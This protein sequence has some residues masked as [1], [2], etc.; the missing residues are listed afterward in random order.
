MDVVDAS[1]R[2]AD[3]ESVT[4]AVESFLIGLSPSD[5]DT[6]LESKMRRLLNKY[7]ER[8]SKEVARKKEWQTVNAE[9]PNP[10]MDHPTDKKQIEEAQQT[11]GNYKLKTDPM[12][13]ASEEERETIAQKLQ[14]LL[15]TREDVYNIRKDYNQK[16]TALRE[17]KRKLYN[18]IKRKLEKL[19]EIHMEIPEKE[20]MKPEV[21]VNFEFDD[22]FPERN[23]DLRKYLMPEN[24]N[25]SLISAGGS[26]L[27]QK[28]PTEKLLMDAQRKVLHNKPV[29]ANAMP[30]S[31]DINM[32]QFQQVTKADKKP[33]EWEEELKNL[34]TRR[35]LFEQQQIIEK[36][37]TRIKTFDEE[38][39]KVSDER[40]GVEVESKFKE[41][42][43]LTLNHELMILK[44]FESIEDSLEELV[45]SQDSERKQLES[46]IV[47][48]N[49]DIE[50]AQRAIEE[51]WE[52]KLMID[53]KFNA[54]CSDNKF[55]P[56]LKRV[57][58]KKLQ[59]E[60]QE[61][62]G[63][64]EMEKEISESEGSSSNNDSLEGSVSN[65]EVGMKYLSEDQCPKGCDTKLY[66]LTF[67]LRQE[68]HKLEAAI[69]EKTKEI[70]NFQIDIEIMTERLEQTNDD[71]DASKA[72]LTELRQKKQKMLNEVHT[73]VCL[74]MDQMQYF[75]NQ[76][77]FVDIDNT[78]L[79]NNHNVTKLYSRVGKL[80]LETIEAKRKHRINVIH[81]AKMKTD[82]KF[83]EK[84]ITDLKDGTNQ[85][86]LKKFGRVIDLNEVEE[87]ILRRFAFEMQVEM[88]AN[89]EDIK[90]QYFNKINELKK[91]KI[92]KEENLKRIIQEA[93]E[94]LNI[95]T[96]LEEEKNFLRRIMTLQSRKQE[97]K[98]AGLPYREIE[99]DLSKL[100]E[101]SNHQKE[102]IEMLQREIRALTLKSK[103][104]VNAR[105]DFESL[106]YSILQLRGEGHFEDSICSN[107][108]ESM[109]SSTRA[110]TPD[111]EVYNEI[112]SIV[113]RFTEDHL[114]DQLEDVEIENVTLNLAKYLANVSVN[115]PSSDI[116]EILPE[117][118]INFKNFL[119]KHIRLA[120]ENI[121]ELVKVIG[122]CN[123]ANDVNRCDVL[124]E[125]INNTIEAANQTTI[126]SS[127][128]LQVILTEIFKQM[129]IT[130]R[131]GDIASSDCTAEIIQRLSKLNSIQP[132]NVNLE[133]IVEE[134][135][136]HAN[137]NMED[138]ID[139]SILKRILANI[140]AKLRV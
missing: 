8:K 24:Y 92:V 34:R 7:R 46:R 73:V 5:I 52:T 90:R 100:Q 51:L 49:N 89:A 133:E 12:F 82:C 54:S 25:L 9:K 60:D 113:K 79:F 40:Y 98:Q 94:K 75:K 53:Q 137:E 110:T 14:E 23:L 131:F 16:V 4:P 118:I 130:M 26:S 39:E 33:S 64:E 59:S 108:D 57:F 65:L 86:M 91:A 37:D 44:D 84:Q 47:Q 125:I 77:E 95:L 15:Q 112:F 105:Q 42:Y 97:L 128:Y 2:T 109:L 13:E 56:F 61:E 50:S 22:E 10:E 32:R 48:T 83:M 88:R 30:K 66:N 122:H 115:F 43:L 19:D 21:A 35:R 63:D 20:R 17:K 74:K 87:T 104:F 116:D 67:E 70:E 93:T 58:K 99:N 106:N 11:I 117:I 29:E 119:P 6:R 138:D 120:P 85:A 81:L 101:I 140:L 69:L 28:N 126:T 55:S 121:A 114:C 62:N 3:T 76:S 1:I 139:K 124:K 127:S 135:A 41:L 107:P 129:V 31:L 71:Y 72:K 27:G 111:N 45:G 123:E 68:R 96:V 80:A 36:I 102:Q 18:F 134:I 38:V 103:S 132:K 136:E 78:L